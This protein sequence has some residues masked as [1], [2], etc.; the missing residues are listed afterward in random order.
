MCPVGLWLPGVTGRWKALLGHLLSAGQLPP[1]ELLIRL[2]VHHQQPR[3]PFHSLD[4]LHHLGSGN[5]SADST[6]GN[7][8]TVAPRL[9]LAHRP[10]CQGRVA[11]PRGQWA[12]PPTPRFQQLAPSTLRAPDMRAQA[13]RALVSTQGLV[14][15]PGSSPGGAVQELQE[16]ARGENQ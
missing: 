10:L 11:G 2:L 12:P 1:A 14:L 3:L 4:P 5:G 7:P 15:S 8:W 9:A 6:P 13:A 16:A